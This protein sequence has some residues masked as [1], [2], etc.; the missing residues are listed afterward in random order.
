M[1]GNSN[2]WAGPGV[3]PGRPREGWGPP[4]ASKAGW[5]GAGGVGV[6]H[7]QQ[8]PRGPPQWESDSPTMG[9]RPFDDGTSIWGGNSKAGLAGPPGGESLLYRLYCCYGQLA[10]GAAPAPSHT[11]GLSDQRPPCC[12]AATVTAQP[13]TAVISPPPRYSEFNI[14]DMALSMFLHET[15]IF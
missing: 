3:E 8:P 7:G 1:G 10:A 11:A 14:E 12:S 9:R 2:Q 13:V 4:P 15:T 6:P 5:Q